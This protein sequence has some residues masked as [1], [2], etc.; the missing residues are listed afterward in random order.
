[1]NTKSAQAIKFD[2]PDAACGDEMALGACGDHL[3]NAPL[4]EGELSIVIPCLNEADTIGICIAKA[5]QVLH[6]HH[7][8]GEVIIADNGSTDGSL[9]IAAKHGARIVQVEEKGY[10][11]ALM[12]GIASARCKFIVM[13][14][15][16]DSYDFR[17]IPKFLEKLREGFDLVQGCRLPWGGG[18]IMDGAMPTTHRWLGNPGFT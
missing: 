12:G 14:D 2:M 5:Q 9:E 18:T 8:D 4:P 17:E 6:E 15:A 13:G 16:D 1:M 3:V 11:H 10:G 7:I